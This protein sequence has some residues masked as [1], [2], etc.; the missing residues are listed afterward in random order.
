MTSGRLLYCPYTGCSQTSKRPWNMRI[1]IKRK[2]GGRQPASASIDGSRFC[3]ETQCSHLPSS[4][5][6][7]LPNHHLKS[8]MSLIVTIHLLITWRR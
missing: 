4:I 7:D 8:K 2:H 3:P 1:H 6:G 5:M